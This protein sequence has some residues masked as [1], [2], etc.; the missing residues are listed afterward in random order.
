MRDQPSGGC[1]ATAT[2][3]KGKKPLITVPDCEPPK[4]LQKVDVIVG[5]GAELKAG[6]TATLHYVGVSWSTKKQFDSSWDRGEPFPSQIPGELIV[7][8]N[9][10][11]PGMKVGGRRL[12]TIPPDKG[13]GDRGAGA[14]IKPGETLV[15]AIDLVSAK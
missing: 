2:A 13:Y 7:G 10:G 14:D 3:Q 11:V 1:A 4:T 15:F 5:T 12:L 6:Q 8:W 9:E